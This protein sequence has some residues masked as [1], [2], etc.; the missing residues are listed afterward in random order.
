[1]AGSDFRPP[2]YTGTERGPLC[3]PYL[4]DTDATFDPGDLV[5]YDTSDDTIDECGADP[6]NILGWAMEKCTAGVLRQ[7]LRADGKCLVEVIDPGVEYGLPVNADVS[8]ANVSTKYGLVKLAS[9]NWAVDLS[10]TTNTRVI[11][12]R[13]GQSGRGVEQIAFVHFLA[14]NLQFSGI[15]S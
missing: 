6:A 14:A 11:I 3:L 8:D 15:V 5:F 7:V 12:V 4:P 13:I 2:Y 1:M 10:D 9:G